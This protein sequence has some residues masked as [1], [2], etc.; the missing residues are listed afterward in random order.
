MDPTR[1]AG[2][3]VKG[4]DKF[5]QRNM[6]DAFSRQMGM[7]LRLGLEKFLGEVFTAEFKTKEIEF[8]IEE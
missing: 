4:V 7:A 5:F 2:I 8:V 1:L 6:P 3:A